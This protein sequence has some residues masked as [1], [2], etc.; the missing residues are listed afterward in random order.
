MVFLLLINIPAGLILP[1]FRFLLNV[2]QSCKYYKFGMAIDTLHNFIPKLKSHEVVDTQGVH[3]TN[4]FLKRTLRRSRCRDEPKA[5]RL[6]LSLFHLGLA[7]I[8]VD[9]KI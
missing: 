1:I 2:F 4:S 7:G 3:I 6:P 9:L 8:T 5:S